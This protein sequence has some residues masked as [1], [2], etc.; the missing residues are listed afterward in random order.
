M[1]YQGDITATLMRAISQCAA[2]LQITKPLP[3]LPVFEAPPPPSG[4]QVEDEHHEKKERWGRRL[5]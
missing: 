2:R 4:S 3:I 5:G 1:R